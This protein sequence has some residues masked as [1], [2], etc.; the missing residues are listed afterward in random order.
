[1]VRQDEKVED[2]GEHIMTAIAT[3]QGSA[4][5]ISDSAEILEAGSDKDDS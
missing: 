2:W 1:M 5:P 3:S 4:S